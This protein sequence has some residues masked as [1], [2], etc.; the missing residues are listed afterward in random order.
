MTASR[1]DRSLGDRELDIMQALWR[2]GHATVSEVQG[3]LRGQS[4]EIA[5]TTIQTMLNRLEV[6]GLVARDAA[7]RAHAYRPLVKEPAEAGG[8]IRRLTER[9]FQGSVEALAAH[10]VERD[11]DSEQLDRIQALIDAQRRKEDRR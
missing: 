7:G 5:Y 6:K 3:H 9:F 4:V 8:A 1:G 10:L 11:L 2:L